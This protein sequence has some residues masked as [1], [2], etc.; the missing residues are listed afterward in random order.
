MSANLCIGA[1]DVH[2][3]SQD[4]DVVVA[5]EPS[6]YA[7]LLVSACVS[8]RY[9]MYVNV[10]LVPWLLPTKTCGNEA[11]LVCACFEERWV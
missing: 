5:T 7:E 11:M 8:S 9:I 3:H 4:E 6:R 2:K 10:S 1:E